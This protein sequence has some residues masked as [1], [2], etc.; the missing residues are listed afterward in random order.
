MAYRLWRQDDNGQ[1]ALMATFADRATAEAQA[2][3]F[4]ARAHKQ[5]YWVE[6]DGVE[7][8]GV[9]GDGV[10]GDGVKRDGA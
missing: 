2:T 10:E 3:A 8:D 1:R 4:E 5:L 7:G 9:E 6:D